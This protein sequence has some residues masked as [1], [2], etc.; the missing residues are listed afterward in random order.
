MNS[1][2]IKRIIIVLICSL[3]LNYCGN[4]LIEMP[5]IETL[6]DGLNAFIFFT[7]LFPFVIVSIALISDLFKSIYKLA[8]N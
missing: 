1:N 8:Y 7:C 2:N 5:N 4:Y 3:G 6:L